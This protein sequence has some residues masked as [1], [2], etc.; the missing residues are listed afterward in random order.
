MILDDVNSADK[1]TELLGPEILDN[2]YVERTRS[3]R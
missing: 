1:I 2:G 3:P